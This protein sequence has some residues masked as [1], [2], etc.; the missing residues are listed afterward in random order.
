MSQRTDS[1]SLLVETV[2]AACMDAALKAYED[3]GI[4]YPHNS[5]IAA[6]PKVQSRAACSVP[7]IIGIF[8]ANRVAARHLGVLPAVVP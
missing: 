2:R 3:A 6:Q 4:R 5:T 7:R 8:P 1:A